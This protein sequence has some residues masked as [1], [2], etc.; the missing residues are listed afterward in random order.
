MRSLDTVG[1]TAKG[2]SR[3]NV[4]GSKVGSAVIIST[5]IVIWSAFCP[6]SGVNV[7][8]V[9]TAVFRFAGLQFPVMLFKDVVGNG[10]EALNWQRGAIGLKTGTTVCEKVCKVGNTQIKKT[11]KDFTEFIIWG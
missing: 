10:D 7:Y 6:G 3:Q 1:N 8:D 5:V 9:V 2:S 4:I 11:R